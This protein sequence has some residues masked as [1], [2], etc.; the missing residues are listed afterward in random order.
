MTKAEKDAL[1]AVD[2]AEN[3][4]DRANKKSSKL[5]ERGLFVGGT[6]GGAA[7]AAVLDRKIGTIWG[8][9]ASVFAG[10][11]GLAAVSMDWIEGKNEDSILA[12]SLGA[13]APTVYNKTFD[14]IEEGDWLG[15]I[16]DEDDDDDDDD[17]DED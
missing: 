9:P 17:T 11:L 15:G 14:V 7:L 10:G 6:L 2:K 1:D 4:A 12:M 13:V 5:L 8:I 3:K 16:L